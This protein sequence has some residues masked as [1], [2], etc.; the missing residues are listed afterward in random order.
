MLEVTWVVFSLIFAITNIA[1]V[2]VLGI[3]FLRDKL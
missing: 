2:I 1:I 3:L